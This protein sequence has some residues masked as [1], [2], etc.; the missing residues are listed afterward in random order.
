MVVK[1]NECSI[2]GIAIFYLALNNRCTSTS[3]SFAALLSSQRCTAIEVKTA[4][5]L[6]LKWD[7]MSRDAHKITE[8]KKNTS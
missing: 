4:C 6:S 8:E 2:R 7:E 5:R 1:T 3:Y